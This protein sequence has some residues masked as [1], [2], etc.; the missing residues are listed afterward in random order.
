MGSRLDFDDTLREIWGHV[1]Y[2]V[3]AGYKMF[4]PAIIYSLDFA[5]TTFA[6]NIPYRVE[7]RYQVMVVTKDPDSHLVDRVA[8]LPTAVLQTTFVQD[9]LYHFSFRVYA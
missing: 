6:D 2:N 1:Y 8:Q 9:S 4:Y 5:D 7:R 3:P